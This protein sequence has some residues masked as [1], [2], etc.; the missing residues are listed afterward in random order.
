MKYFIIA[1]ERSGDL[2][3][4]SLIKQ[5]LAQSP[6]SEVYAWGGNMMQQAGAKLLQHY[7]LISF[8]GFIEFIKCIEFI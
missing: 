4:S 7:E 3:A 2:H 6:E 8:M 1:G 5:L